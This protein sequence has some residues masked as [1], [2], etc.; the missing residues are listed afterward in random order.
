MPGANGEADNLEDE[1][2]EEGTESDNFMTDPK[3]PESVK[4]E[5]KKLRAKQAEYRTKNKELAKVAEEYNQVKST[6]QKEE[7][8][9]AVKNGEAV[10]LL[11]ARNTEV[12]TL[13]AEITRL[14]A[15]EEKVKAS[16]DP[17]IKALPKLV[18]DLMPEGMNTEQTLAWIEKAE[19]SARESD[20]SGNNRIGNIN[21]G[22][23]NGKANE[24]QEQI[25]ATFARMYNSGK[26]YG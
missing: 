25:D 12:A 3:I 11:E 7:E 13:K 5:I 15:I 21:K 22:T 14:Q 16:F 17:R 10:K 24:R 19:K 2:Q 8:E 20:N 6:K 26:Y 18:Q 9:S 1:Q 23:P 4:N